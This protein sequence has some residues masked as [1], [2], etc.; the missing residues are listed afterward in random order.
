MEPRDEPKYFPV[1]TYIEQI[2]QEFHPVIVLCSFSEIMIFSWR[3]L[4]LETYFFKIQ[5]NIVKG[6]GGGTAIDRD[7]RVIYHMMFG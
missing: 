2:T 6:G 1:K 5:T 7:D 3:P 4:I